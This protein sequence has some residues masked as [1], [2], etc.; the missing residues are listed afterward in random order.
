MEA[1]VQEGQE[2]HPLADWKPS[3]NVS[4]KEW[5]AEFRNAESV[6]HKLSLLH[7]GMDLEFRYGGWLDVMKFYFAVAE[8]HTGNSRILNSFPNNDYEHDTPFGEM[9]LKDLPVVLAH[10]A[11]EVICLRI[12]KNTEKSDS[13][14]PSWAAFV[15]NE[16]NFNMLLHFFRLKDDPSNRPRFVN[17][18]YFGRRDGGHDHHTLIAVNFL[19]ELVN[20]LWPLN[21]HYPRI[22]DYDEIKQMFEK[23]RQKLIE[24]LLGIDRLW[25]LV[26]RVEQIT[27]GQMGWLKKMA[28]SK[29]SSSSIE[30]AAWNGN[31]V[32]RVWII[33][34]VLKR[35]GVRQLKIQRAQQR[36]A[37][38]DSELK[39]LG[40]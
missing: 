36:A 26:P 20:R 19:E 9:R 15:K 34:E 7:Y 3:C 4:A 22:W 31:E 33:L 30:E 39:R 28:L 16:E 29:S 21:D 17:L 40:A 24:I 5:L 11:F 27:A 13:S 35:E 23:K 12:L 25:L 18:K 1:K 38:A 10:K 2:Q 32:A 14:V 8:G 37:D 6:Y